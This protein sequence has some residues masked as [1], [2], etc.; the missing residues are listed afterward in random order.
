ATSTLTPET[1]FPS[2]PK[3]A[4]VAGLPATTLG[5]STIVTDHVAFA[6][7]CACEAPPSGKKIVTTTNK[8]NMTPGE[9]AKLEKEAARR[10]SRQSDT[11]P[12]RRAPSTRTRASRG[13]VGKVL[14]RSRLPERTP[15]ESRARAPQAPRVY[16]DDR[17]Q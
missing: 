4:S 1:S 13:T 17:K 6:V 10:D 2:A 15:P 12:K 16:K 5:G 9:K 11:I 8:W 3:T 14:H 7:D